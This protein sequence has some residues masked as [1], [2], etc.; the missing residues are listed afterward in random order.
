MSG[1]LADVFYELGYKVNDKG[2][3]KVDKALKTLGKKATELGPKLAGAIGAG[4]GV[5][6]YGINKATNEFALFDD[7]LRKVNAK[8]DMTKESYN[9]LKN[10]AFEAGR[11]TRFSATQS[12]KGL[13]FMAMAGWSA[14]ESVKAL[15]SALNMAV[16]A[17]E[18]LSLVTDIMTDQMTVFNLG[19]EKAE[20]FADVLAYSAN[21]SNTTV[22]M[23]GEAMKY[24]GPPMVALGS[25]VEETAA[26]FMSMADGGIKA[27]QAGTTLRTAALRL[28]N[29]NKEAARVIRK[30]K[31]ETQDSTGNFIGMTKIMEQLE[32]KTK[33]MTNVQKAQVL[34][35]LVGK[36]AISGFMVVMSQG[37][38]KIN[39][40]T[41]ALK[42][43]NGYA[44]KAA[45]YMNNSLQG[46]LYGATS[47]QESL[48]L[49]I[50]ET[51][52]PAKLELV[53]AYNGLLDSMITKISDSTEETEQLSD[54]TVGFISIM[55][56]GMK[57]VGEMIYEGVVVP[58]KAVY[59]VA[60]IL[61]LGLLSK[62][63]DGFIDHVSE[64][65]AQKRAETTFQG[66]QL[67]KTYMNKAKE[68]PILGPLIPK[69]E[70]PKELP[71]L[72]QPY[73]K[74]N[75]ENLNL[76]SPLNVNKSITERIRESQ[77]NSSIFTTTVG[78]ININYP[79]GVNVN[80]PVKMAEIARKEV[81][82]AINAK[83]K[84]L[85]NKLNP[86]RKR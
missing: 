70:R 5:L 63:T 48:S 74:I 39:K 64:I 24:A 4:A 67:E 9:L 20:H 66:E 49:V 65:G 55:T 22:G 14:T 3:K 54:F 10:A 80:D 41:E 2:F 29:P 50:G 69:D 31:L 73:L 79:T 18:D 21:K 77:T 32:E 59:E 7:Q 13:E 16:V 58:L 28:V 45:E 11:E 82:K 42:T 71:N 52:A 6:A 8:G 19:A 35:T 37:T 47:K 83:D 76:K 30:L 44:K 36:Q 38:D 46:A 15:P 57:F 84:E 34:E 75:K 26:L 85:E 40:N 78:D 53:K 12:A 27:S 61:S 25:T 68:I 60:D 56:E 43:N 86:K 17:G 81:V 51:F 1:K 23:L 72:V 33:G 62:A